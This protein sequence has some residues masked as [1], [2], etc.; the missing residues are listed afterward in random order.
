MKLRSPASIWLCLLLMLGQAMSGALAQEAPFLDVSI[1]IFGVPET[2]PVAA[3]QPVS[4]QAVKEANITA[5]IR[6]AEARYLALYLRYRLEASGSFGAVRV[7]PAVDSGADLTI[8]GN[9]LAS[10]GQTLAL[11]IRALDSTGTTWLDKE[12]RGQAVDSESLNEDVLAD[13]VFAYL[14]S[15]IVGD[16]RGQL[17]TRTPEDLARIRNVSLLKYGEGLAPQ[18][19]AGYLQAG[20]DGLVSIIRLP[21]NDDPLYSSIREI[22]EHEYLFIDVVDQEY[23]RFFREIKPVY[24]M[25]RQ[26]RREQT[27]SADNFEARE[28]TDNNQFRPGTYYALQQSYNNYRW[29]KLQELYLDELSEGF[30]NETGDTSIELNDSLFRL[31]GTLE[32]QYREWRSILAEMAALD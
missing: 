10:D 28:T 32:Q 27:S 26:F 12:Y 8:T 24:D 29:A 23:Q 7:L 6:N 3:G 17:A 1:G 18:R 11:A 30:A 19:Y 5:E 25:W 9:V 14:F 4:T 31:T 2:Q 15:A 22:R 21:A 13:E 20:E 16:L